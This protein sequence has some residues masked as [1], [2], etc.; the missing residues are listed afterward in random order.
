MKKIPGFSD[1]NF[2]IV[3]GISRTPNPNDDVHLK[4]LWY[5]QKYK[6]IFYKVKKTIIAALYYAVCSSNNLFCSIVLLSSFIKK[7][8]Q[9]Y[10]LRQIYVQHNHK[11]TTASVFI[12]A[13]FSKI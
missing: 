7:K 8:V 5:S 2:K 11:I 1:H 3:P 4:N 13:F 12:F 9:E 6:I 10:V